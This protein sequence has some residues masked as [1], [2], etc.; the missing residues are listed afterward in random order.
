MFC[1]K[2]GAKVEDGTRFC[3]ECGA[4]IKLDEEDKTE[5]LSEDQVQKV[6]PVL[7]MQPEQSFSMQPEQPF[8]VQVE[9]KKKRGKKPLLILLL[10]FILLLL[11]GTAGVVGY[12]LFM[13]SGISFFQ[14]SEFS[15]MLKKAEEAMEEEDFEA[16]MGYY[17]KALELE[18]ENEEIQDIIDELRKDHPE[19]FE[20]DESEA[21]TEDSALEEEDDAELEK[22]MGE[23]TDINIDVRQV[24][25][26]NFPEITLYA[27]IT[28]KNG[29]TVKEMEKKDFNIQ[30]IA[31][32]GTVHPV[33]IDQVTQVLNEEKINVN[34][35]LD[36]S[37][38]M[39]SNSKMRQAKNAAESLI[40]QMALSHGDKAEIISFDDY[41]YLQ[42]EFTSDGTALND[43]IEGI[44][45]GGMTALYD[46]IYAGLFQT[47]QENGAKCVIAFTDGMENASSY[48]FEDIV[49]MAQN[50]SIPVYI[51]GI[52]DEY[53]D[54]TFLEQLAAECS[55]CYYSADETNLETVLE[56]IYLDIYQ[57]QQDYYVFKYTSPDETAPT[58]FRNVLVETSDYT[59]FSGSYKKAYI[60]QADITGAFSASYMNKDFMIDD[61]DVRE[62]TEAD[63]AGKSLA[64]LRIAR[65]EIFARHGRQF[66]DHMLN[67]W[68]YSKTWYLNIGAKYAPDD[69]D[70]MTPNPLSAL[71]LRNANF[72]KDYE[73]KIMNQQDIYPDAANTLLSDYDLALSKAVLKNA[74]S[75]MQ[76]YPSTATLEENKK[77]VQEAMNKQDIQ[78]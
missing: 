50:T 66:K 14:N 2:C 5:I 62:I 60:P 15:G 1:V 23:K 57:Q 76:N 19:L 67:Q 30:E 4:P 58:E 55:G 27:S 71:E 21:K 72:I 52:G 49:N 7:S 61:S 18:P 31:T 40:T 70:K 16:A 47:H 69:F 65:N 17:L 35:V 8:P 63:L 78:Y 38:S 74:Y 36:A 53:Y 33:S 32:D 68:F 48:S 75:Q 44:G 10:I 12:Q 3:A 54:S 25:A 29:E 11:L 73:E 34:L 26:S 77:Q 13:G 28:D 22:Y 20:E 39:D 42:Q 43:A 56:S 24:D 64:E 37:G 6:E 9:Q 45:T 41:V 59:E 51:I 46:A